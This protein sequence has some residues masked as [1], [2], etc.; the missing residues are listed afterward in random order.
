MVNRTKPAAVNA[1]GDVRAIIESAGG[2]VTDEVEARD[3]SA[4]S[5]DGADVVVVLGG[6]GTFLSAAR[7][8][9]NTNAPMIGV[10]FGRL[11]FLAEFDLDSLKA[12]A[13]HLFGDEPLATDDRALM[14]VVARCGT[15]GDERCRKLALNDA[16]IVAGP[17]YRMIRIA[18]EFDGVRGP[19]IDGD[20]VII[21]TPTG[22]TGYS[23][24]AGGPIISPSVD[25]LSISAIAA[26]SLGFRPLVVP[27]SCQVLLRME[28]VNP[29][30]DDADSQTNGNGGTTLVLDGQWRQRVHAGDEILIQRLPTGVRV[31]RNTERSYFETLM[32][33]MHWASKPGL[34]S[35]PNN[36]MP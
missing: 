5:I 20:G 32:E 26:H 10:N 7:S 6:D 12:Q 14:Q 23:V 27:G 16:A 36:A 3:G 25:A 33:K 35:S 9:A 30:D 2:R 22:S 29:R 19:T 34:G 1:A 31:V 17:P 15:S 28:I 11:G 21:A 18:M 4:V 24:S 8:L 13:T